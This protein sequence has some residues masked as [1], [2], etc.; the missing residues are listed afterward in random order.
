MNEQTPA[1]IVAA[2]IP[3]Q[4]ITPMQMLQIAVEK[5][6]DLDQ[7]DK[8]MALQERWEANE[9]RKAFVVAKAAFK[10]ESPTISKNKH[11]GF[12]SSRGG[13]R[14][15]YYHATLDNVTNELGPLLAEHGLSYS[16]ETDQPEGGQI[17]VTCVLTHVAGHSERVTLTAA[18]D[19]S[20]NKNSIQAVGST[21]TY[22]QR[23]TL[24]AITGT[25]TA[26]EDSDGGDTG[27]VI[28][29]EQLDRLRA[30]CDESNA[31]IP[32]FCKALGISNLT[33]LPARRFDEAIE[34]LAA[35][36]TALAGKADD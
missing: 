7:L 11:V 2:E 25:A 3:A 26:G 15:D 13:G 30:L 4:P 21:V 32:K 20:G 33:A 1:K 27:D 22:L 23:Y 31:D 5:G 36:K 14:T 9:A 16:W 35:R 6:T 24:L 28:E 29:H 17:S 18:A 12:D 34:R 10:A 19:S 8:L